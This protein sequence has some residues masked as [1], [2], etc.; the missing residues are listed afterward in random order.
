MTELKD[1]LAALR[2]ER[3]PERSGGSRWIG[4]TL[5]ALLLAAAA[6][7]AS[8]W[9]TR[10]RPIDVEVVTVTGRAAGAQAVALNAS[11]YVT[12]RRRATAVRA[13]QV[14]A[15]L[16]DSSIRA[17]LTLA[18][19]QVGAARQGVRES[20]VRLAEARLTLSRTTQ[21]FERKL[22]TEADVDRAR[23]EVDSLGARI[24]ATREQVKVAERQVELRGRT[25]TTPSF[26]RRL[27]VSR[28]R[29]MRSR[30]R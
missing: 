12:A 13:G 18:E 14:L 2:I 8:F 11:G 10:E 5:V 20:E 28:S 9:Y 1:D 23:A 30:E 29:R 3:E 25:W 21:L 15:R 27:P 7:G 22:V 16:D 17:A 26:A 6:S 24:D 4:W 19:A